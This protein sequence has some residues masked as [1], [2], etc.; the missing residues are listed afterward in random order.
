M[1]NP[2]L[3]KVH[4]QEN[5]VSD[6][7]EPA[8]DSDVVDDPGREEWHIRRL[9]GE[10]TPQEKEE[11]QTRMCKA[12]DAWDLNGLEQSIADGAVPTVFERN[13]LKML[14]SVDESER[15]L[16]S[17]RNEDYRQRIRAQ[18]LMTPE[19]RAAR[20]AAW[21]AKEEMERQELLKTIRAERKPQSGAVKHKQ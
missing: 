14:R 9:K 12:R 15:L 21:E 6:K 16:E 17:I 19:E 11:L 2:V 10:L 20:I 5:G 13:R 7:R 18:Q 4:E 1:I 3:D 8:G